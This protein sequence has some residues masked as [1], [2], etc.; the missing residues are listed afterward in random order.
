MMQAWADAGNDWQEMMVV[1]DVIHG[2]WIRCWVLT[3]K[4][5]FYYFLALFLSKNAY[6]CMFFDLFLGVITEVLRIRKL[7]ACCRNNTVFFGNSF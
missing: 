5:L 7:Q 2:W 6:F 3:K 4:Q 1:K